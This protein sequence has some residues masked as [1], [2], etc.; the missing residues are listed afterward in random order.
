MLRL[1]LSH[2]WLCLWAAFLCLYL[3]NCSKL[4]LSSVLY[5][6]KNFKNA[7][8]QIE[9]EL[10]YLIWALFDLLVAFFGLLAWDA[11]HQQSNQFDVS[12]DK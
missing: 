7:R 2:S 8:I 12:L 6:F 3:N 9:L 11:L 10:T 4:Y 5:H 1:Y